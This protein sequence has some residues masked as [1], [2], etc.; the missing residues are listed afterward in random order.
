M[1]KNIKS[2]FYLLNLNIFIKIRFESMLKK[3]ISYAIIFS[4]F[5][6]DALFCMDD[7]APGQTI[8]YRKPLPDPL[9]KTNPPV[10]PFEKKPPLPPKSSDSSASKKPFLSKKRGQIS[11]GHNQ[12]KS[13]ELLS[14][15][16]NATNTYHS[17]SHSLSSTPSPGSDETPQGS[18][19]SGEPFVPTQ[20]S[21][22]LGGSSD[23]SQGSTPPNSDGSLSIVAPDVLLVSKEAK[24]QSAIGRRPKLELPQNTEQKNAQGKPI[25]VMEGLDSDSD[26][27]DIEFKTDC[28]ATAP[29]ED[30]PTHGTETKN[31][32]KA[33]LS[34]NH[35]LIDLVGDST[36]SWQVIGEKS[37]Q[38]LIQA[39]RS[40]NIQ[41]KDGGLKI[42]LAATDH[43]KNFFPEEKALFIKR[44]GGGSP[45]E[46]EKLF[47]SLSPK[48]I[49]TLKKN[50]AW[51]EEA[52][53]MTVGA[54]VGGT[55]AYTFSG[56]YNLAMF[57]LATQVD[58]D[59]AVLL[60]GQ[61]LFYAII[62]LTVPDLVIHNALRMKKAL[63][64][65]SSP[66]ANKK[67]IWLRLASASTIATVTSFA[68]V[69]MVLET[70]EVFPLPE[71]DSEEL[72]LMPVCTFALFLNDLGHYIHEGVTVRKWGQ[73]WVQTSDTWLA[74]ITGAV[75]YDSPP[76]ED[77][78]RQ[79]TFNK[80][81]GLLRHNL[82][83][84]SDQNIGEMSTILDEIEQ[85]EEAERAFYTTLFFL[86]EGDAMEQRIASS[87]ATI[88]AVLEHSAQEIHDDIAE[89][90]LQQTA[91]SPLLVSSEE[92][93]NNSLYKKVTYLTNWFVITCGSFSRILLSKFI[94]SEMFRYTV[95]AIG[96]LV[97]NPAGA[98][99][100]NV[101]P[102]AWTIA[103]A[104][105]LPQSVFDG[106]RT[107]DF[108]NMF[109]RIKDQS[110]RE[111]GVTVYA[112]LLG[113][114]RIAPEG[115]LALLA[116]QDQFG[117]DWLWD[118]DHPERK[119]LTL[120]LI[121]PYLIPEWAAQ[122]TF[123]EEA[124]NEELFPALEDICHSSYVW[125]T[126]EG[127]RDKYNSLQPPEPLKWESNPRM[128][129]EDKI[130]RKLKAIEET[131]GNFHPEVLF[132]LEKAVLGARNSNAS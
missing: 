25:N 52:I 27:S 11:V 4:I 120:T 90:T 100:I 39:N 48:A 87:K 65:L 59:F 124:Y 95:L 63:A 9:K 58:D 40:L 16:G 56:L 132:E 71:V 93:E 101:E 75:F 35:E 115:V 110:W 6:S 33:D 116:Y 62:F 55:T 69:A 14:L 64:Y 109:Q 43:L 89:E 92:D 5:Y 84:M 91:L 38:P 61:G 111:R 105:F 54:A 1:R 77:T 98:A 83:W 70:I 66:R 94:F 7:P 99:E 31:S 67:D 18:P 121:L 19:K 51:W 123:I 128:H 22:S 78:L 28:G 50:V 72:K 15:L 30:K 130:N 13:S 122:T 108:F 97:G 57:H 127:M 17:L 29:F 112:L 37:S 107:A 76:S 82:S 3:I 117:K 131:I 118:S 34:N 88:N 104:I 73:E 119:A 46:F 41:E 81:L 21:S 80:K 2:S 24:P 103:S 96:M 26:I 126:I 68:V 79:R 106:K 32:G 8:R 49:V 20:E 86:L 23:G 114:I 129:A 45:D 36:G 47:N 74:R 53:G 113:L 12:A 125:P 10:L 102:L 42:L 85:R 44:M 60:D